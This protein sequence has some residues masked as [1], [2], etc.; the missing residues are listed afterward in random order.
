MK[1]ILSTAGALALGLVA[2]VEPSSRQD[3]AAASPAAAVGKPA[4]SFALND[5]EGRAVRVGGEAAGWTVLAFYP[6]ASTPG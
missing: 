6:K 1:H 2:L 5:H 3:Q 4:P